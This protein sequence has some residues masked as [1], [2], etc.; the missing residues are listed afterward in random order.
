MDENMKARGIGYLL[1][2]SLIWGSSFAVVKDSLKSLTPMWNLAARFIFA[3]IFMVLFC[4]KS[5]RGLS[6]RNIKDGAILGSILF[7][8][9]FFQSEGINRTTAGKSAFITNI[10]VIL[11]PFTEFLWKGKKL[12]LKDIVAAVI[13]MS[14]IG[15]ITLDEGLGIGSGDILCLVCGVIYAFYIIKIDD[16]P[17]KVSSEGIHTIQII[18]CG[19]FSVMAAFLLEPFP[20]SIAGKAVLGTFYCGVF[21]LGIGFL[22]QLKGQKIISPT[23]SGLV[24]SLE[25]ITACIF[26][27]FILGEN[28]SFKMFIG[29]IM[30]LI[31]ILIPDQ[32]NIKKSEII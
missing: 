19:V 2:C 14:G 22:F 28:V 17:Q 15:F 21:E 29:C 18:T 10:Y 16:I 8:A 6:K 24:M 3:S 1:I 32:S 9:M 5:L 4:C 12:R 7:C 30:V 31:S 20:K 25:S 11:I 13:C 23:I 27:Y 26:S